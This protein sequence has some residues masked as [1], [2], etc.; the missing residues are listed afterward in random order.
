MLSE[1]F[2]D[3]AVSPPAFFFRSDPS[4]FASSFEVLVPSGP[5]VVGLRI[6]LASGFTSLL[7]ITKTIWSL[8][9]LSWYLG[10]QTLTIESSLGRVAQ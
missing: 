1:E 2:P 9:S 8:A 7:K 5:A 3:E 6:S 10:G 4:P